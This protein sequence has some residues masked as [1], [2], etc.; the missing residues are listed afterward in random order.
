MVLLTQ[1]DGIVIRLS[2]C[3]EMHRLADL[4]LTLVLPRHVIGCRSVACLVGDL[5]RLKKVNVSPALALAR[6]YFLIFTRQQGHQEA[7]LIII[8]IL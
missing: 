3:V 1:P 7:G 2:T 8:T 6:T 5:A 4:I